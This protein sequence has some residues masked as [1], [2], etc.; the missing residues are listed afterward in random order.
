MSASNKAGRSGAPLTVVSSSSFE[1]LLAMPAGDTFFEVLE[2]TLVA[3]TSPG[4]DH[5]MAVTELF[6]FLFKAYQA[7]Y[8][9]V[10]TAPF[11]VVFD[12]PVRGVRGR[13][14]AHPDLFFIRQDRL[15]IIGRTC[16]EDAPD[17][18]VEVL[19]P[20]TRDIDEGKPGA[21][22]NKFAMYERYAVP[23]YWIV[24]TDAQ[25]IRLYTWAN[26]VYLEPVIAKP[27]DTLTCPL[28]AE[29]VLDVALVFRHIHGRD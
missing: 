7:G 24:D 12:Y 16:I 20:T 2:G 27:G 3:T 25:T 26:G 1:D 19:S 21:S 22:I 9:R 6:G 14:A 17:L 4:G 28:F 13:D 15:G 5:A 10:Y 8:G 23:Y 11:S 18:V 29:I